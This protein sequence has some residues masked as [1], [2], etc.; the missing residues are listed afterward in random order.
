MRKHQHRWS[1]YQILL[2]INDPL[3]PFPGR[4]LRLRQEQYRLLWLGCRYRS[5]EL[6]D[7]RGVEILE[8]L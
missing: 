5:K 3:P 8:G 2:R 7:R 6:G 1:G 4:A